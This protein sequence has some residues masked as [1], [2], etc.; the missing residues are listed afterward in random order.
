MLE[1]FFAAVLMDTVVAPPVEGYVE[2]H[3]WGAVTFTQE[4]VIFGA[5]PGTDPHAAPIP[6]DQWEEPLARAPVVY[7][8]GEPFSGTFT[9]NVAAGSFIEL[10]PVP[11]SLMDTSPMPEYPSGTA[12]WNITMAGPYS[13]EGGMPGRERALTSC[14]TPELLEIWREPPAMLLQ[15]ED[16]SSEKFVYYECRL[17]SPADSAYYPVLMTGDGPALDPEWEGEILRCVRTGESV[18]LELDSEEATEALEPSDV[19]QLLCDWSG[20]H[21][22]SQELQAMWRTWEDW[23][24]GG[25]WSGDTLEIF[26][27]PGSTVEGI[28]S[29]SLETDEYMLVEYRR[30]FLGMIS[31]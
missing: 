11:G 18:A 4:N 12:M 20:G 16:G 19:H 30:F 21:M 3:E 10:Y 13:E 29:I 7:F 9:V 2:V 28:S 27:L 23:V 17:N 26:T 31:R 22:K 5:D 15:F 14:V 1:L 6:P 8:H 24:L 25:E